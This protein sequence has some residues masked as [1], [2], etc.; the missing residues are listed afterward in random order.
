M[1]SMGFMCNY[2]PTF[3]AIQNNK[4]RSI[5]NNFFNI[6]TSV[7]V[8]GFFLS[9]QSCKPQYTDVKL[10]KVDCCDIGDA[11]NGK[12]TVGFGLDVENPN[13]FDINI[14]EMNVNVK[15]NG[16]EVGEADS[17]KKFKLLKNSR[18][19]YKMEVTA[20]INKILAGSLANLGAL[21]SG[22]LKTMDAEIEGEIK[23][24]AMGITRTIPVEG[25][26]P[27]QLK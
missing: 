3:N 6:V 24:S 4:M 21:L 15:I 25:T 8:V 17:E 26:Y 16:I 19:I 20:D 5:P 23:A 22:G 11:V 10:H 18:N 7:F 2:I 13:K 1:E 12:L 14:K 9:F 27:I